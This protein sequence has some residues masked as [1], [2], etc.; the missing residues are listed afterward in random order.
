ME[1]QGKKF[2][3]FLKELLKKIDDPKCENKTFME[4]NGNNTKQ[5]NSYLKSEEDSNALHHNEILKIASTFSVPG[6]ERKEEVW[7]KLSKRI[8]NEKSTIKLQQTNQK[9]IRYSISIAATILLIIGT[10]VFFLNQNTIIK[11]SKGQH[12]SYMLPDSSEIIMNSETWIK[13][14]KFRYHWSRKIELTGEAIFKVKKGKTFEVETQ[15]SIIT[16]LGTT[17][18]VYSRGEELKVACITGKVMVSIPAL[19]DN[20]ILLPDYKTEKKK[21]DGLSTPVR[22]NH[23]EGPVWKEGKFAYTQ[24]PLLNVLEEIERQ[25]NVQINCKGCENRIY[26]GHF[27]NNDLT[28]SLI[29]VCEPMQLSFIIKD[30][31]NV[32]LNPKTN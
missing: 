30:K 28:E 27:Y 7:E 10:A 3:Q 2:I 31:N 20:K 29:M 24:E 14:S 8:D 9:F 17:F 15:N 18:N 13:F 5:I 21:G 6:D 25:F 1:T 22:F 26:T 4:T 12:L 32:L 11:C 19:K 16:V 23:E